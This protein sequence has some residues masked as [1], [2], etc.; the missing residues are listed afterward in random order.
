MYRAALFLAPLLVVSLSVSSCSSG[1]GGG[2]GGGANPPTTNPNTIPEAT[3][4]SPTGTLSGDVAFQVTVIDADGDAVSLDLEFSTDGGVTYVSLTRSAGSANPMALPAD[5]DGE[6]YSFAWDTVADGVGAAA[7]ATGVTLRVTPRDADSGLAVTSTPFDVDNQPSSVPAVSSVSP[8]FGPAGTLIV[9]EGFN[10]GSDL[11]AFVARVGGVTLRNISL[12]SG[13]TTPSGTAG[14]FICVTS[15]ELASGPLE[16]ERSGTLLYSGSE[17]EVAPR[18]ERIAPAVVVL[19]GTSITIS[20]RQL[21]AVDAVEFELVG[22]ASTS[23]SPTSVTA[24]AVEVT[25]PA[26]S[27]PVGGAALG[28]RAVAGGVPSNTIGLFYS[29][30]SPAVMPP[31][32][33][34]LSIPPRSAAG[35]LPVDLRVFDTGNT[36]LGSVVVSYSVDGGAFTPCTEGDTALTGALIPASPFGGGVLHRFEWDAEVDLG[37]AFARQ[38]RIRV[39][40]FSQGGVPGARWTSPPVWVGGDAALTLLESFEDNDLEDPAVTTADWNGA[41]VGELVGSTSAPP[42][43]WGTGANG[44]FQPTSGTITLVTDGLDTTYGGFDG[45]FDFS[46]IDIPAGVTVRASGS[47]PLVLR[48]TGDAT[49]DG[50]IDV[51]G[52]NGSAGTMTAAGGGGATTA[53]GTAGG[54]GG[55][56]VS[57]IAIDGED[58][59][60]GGRGGRTTLSLHTAARGGGGGGGGFATAGTNG[61]ST[62]GI[63]SGR[64]GIGGIPRGSADLVDPTLA[65]V[66]GG[67]GGGSVGTSG[68]AFGRGGGG[69]AGGGAVWV[70]AQGV[71]TVSGAIE[72]DGGN[73]GSGFNGGGGGGGSGG[74]VALHSATDVIFESGV[75]ISARGGSGGSGDATGGAGSDGRVVLGSP[76]PIVLPTAGPGGP[77]S[78]FDFTNVVPAPGTPGFSQD[79]VPLATVD[80]GTGADGVFAPVNS[81]T[82]FTDGVDPVY[83]GS[84]GV[85]QF[86]SIDI[87]AGVVITAVGSNPLVLKSTGD[88]TFAGTIDISGQNGMPLPFAPPPGGLGGEGGPGGGRGGDGGY[89]AGVPPILAPPGTDGEVPAGATGSGG[90]GAATVPSPDGTS[91]AGG[92]GGGGFALLGTPGETGVGPLGTAGGEGGDAIGAPDFRDPLD[93]TVVVLHGGSGGGGGGGSAQP[94]AFPPGITMPGAGGGGG[95]GA[96]WIAVA[97]TLEVAAT[98]TIDARGGTGTSN[99]NPFAGA[100]GGGA[101]GGILLTAEAMDFA[102]ATLDATG[103]AGGAGPGTATAGG[104]GSAGRVRVETSDA[105]GGLSGSVEPTAT[106]SPFPVDRMFSVGQSLPIPLTNTEGFPSHGSKLDTVGVGPAM[107]LSPAEVRILWGI[108]QAD[109]NDP[110]V[111]RAFSG[112]TELFDQLPEGAFLQFRV[113][114]ESG[115]IP[116]QPARVEF[117]EAETTP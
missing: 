13:A 9:V 55:S 19:P 93:P 56:I 106:V 100:G 54:S 27:I 61:G 49:I 107:Q 116:S 65:G 102:A 25:V 75:A 59:T 77:G 8:L 28:V 41:V 86:T 45:V 11:S 38:V 71:V 32:L 63:G 14:T 104:D 50:T 67:G 74:L 103:G 114:L 16:I 82:L 4:A 113:L 66:G 111:P 105:A 88:A 57:G 20:G 87:P 98:A 47:N 90:G 5:A 42:A 110:M 62:P 108:W 84:N 37:P 10:F 23:V 80:F 33:T 6:T 21:S 72:A 70:V 78:T 18:L 7:V 94:L 22:G 30:Q 60:R 36:D 51:S 117:I 64:G 96:V 15:P 17:F 68:G 52:A 58:A 79:V 1:G 48:S 69:G 81:V 76:N 2:G 46:V 43:P 101:G 3:V 97:G 73:G 44:P 99:T 92:G 95:G 53:G 83:G 109:P 34:S 24:T 12:T 39:E 112:F 85:F 35:R 29:D 89:F 26:F 115:V 91:V 40:P 31:G